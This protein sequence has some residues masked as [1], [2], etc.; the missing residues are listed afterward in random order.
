PQQEVVPTSDPWTFSFLWETLPAS[1]L[2]ALEQTP[3]Q[4]LVG[5]SRVLGPATQHHKV[6]HK[7]HRL[8]ELLTQQRRRS[9]CLVC[10]KTGVEE[11]RTEV[12]NHP[13]LRP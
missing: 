2:L 12:Q 11:G 5:P 8:S 6:A 7:K 1:S 3:Q 4:A 9:A 13:P 10:L